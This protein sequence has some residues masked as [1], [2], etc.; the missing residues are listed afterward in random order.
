MFKNRRQLLP[1][2]PG[3][4]GPVLLR[5][6]YFLLGDPAATEEIPRPGSALFYCF[7]HS[8]SHEKKKSSNSKKK[9]MICMKSCQIFNEEGSSWG[10]NYSEDA[11]PRVGSIKQQWLDTKTSMWQEQP[12]KDSFFL[13][14]T[15]G[16]YLW[17]CYCD[18]IS[19]QQEQLPRT[20]FNWS[21]ITYQSSLVCSRQRKRSLLLLAYL[22][23][24]YEN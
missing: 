23:T 7:F 2:P 4:E 14:G 22:I 6:S 8:H 19:R 3:A 24:N 5:Q 21:V 15:S 9:R 17:N 20:K 18:L 11:K 13:S 1:R 12:E 16:K 10:I